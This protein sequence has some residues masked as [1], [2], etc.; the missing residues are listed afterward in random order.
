MGILLLQGYGIIE[1]APIVAVNHNRHYKDGSIGTALPCNSIKI[2]DATE[3]GDGE[4]WAGG[5]NV[6][7]GYY[8]KPAK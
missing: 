8:K 4:L 1:C 5:S 6:M 3:E 2:V 7:F